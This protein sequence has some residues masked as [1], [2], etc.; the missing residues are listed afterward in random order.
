[1]KTLVVVALLPISLSVSAAD[2]SLAFKGLVL[3]SSHVEILKRYPNADCALDACALSE[4]AMEKSPETIGGVPITLMVFGLH[5]GRLHTIGLTIP[6]S[7]IDS[8]VSALAERH[9]KPSADTPAAARKSVGRKVTWQRPGGVIH[10][11]WVAKRSSASVLLQSQE[12]VELF[13]N[14]RKK[15]LSDL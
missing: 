11:L 13:D 2:G 12:G 7:G 3:G 4:A 10:V 9:G 14:E 1:M 8:V 15:A 6:V 5:N